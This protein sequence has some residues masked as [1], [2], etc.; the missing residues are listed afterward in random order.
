[1]A[2]I[3]IAIQI[4]FSIGVGLFVMSLLK[5]GRFSVI[6][7]QIQLARGKIEHWPRELRPLGVVLAPWMP[8][9]NRLAQGSSQV[10]RA[11]LT[12]GF[13]PQF[14][15]REFSKMRITLAAITVLIG[16]LAVF[17]CVVVMGVGSLQ[18]GVVGIGV[19]SV[20]AFYLPQLKLFEVYQLARGRISR[21]F[22]SFLDVLSL[23][24]ESGQNFQ[25]ALQMSAQRLPESRF[26]SDLRGQLQEVL[27][28]IRAGESRILALQ[29]FSDR[30]GLPEVTQF[31]ASVSAAERQGVS[32]SA[33]LRRQAE[34]L[35]SSRA[36]SAE[37][38]AMKMP[39]KLLAPLAICIFPCTF[40]V[41]AFPIA[42]RLS[43]SG[44]F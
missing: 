12:L 35:R 43:H 31:V 2:E 30:L 6:R 14:D 11:L 10:K 7:T 3:L 15:D 25:S 38:H 16:V 1:M 21:A 44:L 5:K 17:Y 18:W 42:I 24:L 13:H 29:K 26:R 20:M 36:L 39:V 9:S 27:R 37:R 33:L 41:L 4:I 28:E 34:Q 23:T 19:A 22:P 32:V 40:L 8:L